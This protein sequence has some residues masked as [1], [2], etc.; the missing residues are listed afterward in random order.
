MLF[1][2]I[3]QERPIFKASRQPNSSAG[4][5]AWAASE[6]SPYPVEYE[7]GKGSHGTIWFGRRRTTIKARTKDIPPGLFA[8]MLRQ[9]GL[10]KKDLFEP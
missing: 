7:R 9:L 1:L 8:A 4:S 3:G 5:P 10:T 2:T 6:A